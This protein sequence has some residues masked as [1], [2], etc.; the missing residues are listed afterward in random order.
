MHRTL[1]AG[2]DTTWLGTRFASWDLERTY[3][4]DLTQLQVVKSKLPSTTTTNSAATSVGGVAVRVP[5]RQVARQLQVVSAAALVLYSLAETALYYHLDTRGH[6][7]AFLKAD[8]GHKNNA[9]IDYEAHVHGSLLPWLIAVVLLF[10][11]TLPYWNQVVLSRLCHV[12]I[13]VKHDGDAALPQVVD[14]AEAWRCIATTLGAV[15]AVMLV[16]SVSLARRFAAVPLT[17]EW[18]VI[19]LPVA[20]LLLIHATAAP[21]WLVL[22]SVLPSQTP[23][24]CWRVDASAI[25]AENARANNN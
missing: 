11:L 14:E 1:G 24:P 2:N 4:T 23:M 6:A 8:H 16:V 20:W 19:V 22:P 12:R 17:T 7:H 5:R 10:G 18:A 25:A 3:L 13:K 15:C 21:S 9:I